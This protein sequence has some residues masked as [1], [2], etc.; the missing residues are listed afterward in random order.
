MSYFLKFLSNL[1]DPNLIKD[2]TQT[3]QVLTSEELTN[4]TD[5]HPRAMTLYTYLYEKE[6]GHD[7]LKL[8]QLKKY[9][10]SN[11]HGLFFRK[12]A[13]FKVNTTFEKFKTLV[14]ILTDCNKL[15]V[16]DS[17]FPHY[18]RE[19]IVKNLQSIITH[20]ITKNNSDETSKV[21]LET[22]ISFYKLDRSETFTNLIQIC[23]LKNF[24]ITK[25]FLTQFMGIKLDSI[26]IVDLILNYAMNPDFPLEQ[27]PDLTKAIIE[28]SASISAEEWRMILKH[29]DKIQTFNLANK[30]FYHFFLQECSINVFDLTASS[31]NLLI[32]ESLTSWDIF[33]YLP[34]KL[35]PIQAF[36]YSVYI[37]KNNPSL[38]RKSI[39]TI[40]K[41]YLEIAHKENKNLTLEEL[42]PQFPMLWWGCNKNAK[43]YTSA[44]FWS[45]LELIPE[46]IPYL[47]EGKAPIIAQNLF[48]EKG[49]IFNKLVTQLLNDGASKGEISWAYLAY[50]VLVNKLLKNRDDFQSVY[51][52]LEIKGISSNTY[53]AFISFFN[54]SFLPEISLQRS[55]LFGGINK[56]T[57]F[58]LLTQD[59]DYSFLNDCFEMMKRL[60]SLKLDFTPPQGTA[61]W[62]EYHDYLLEE[63]QKIKVKGIKLQQDHLINALHNKEFIG[64]KVHV[65]LFS[66]DFVW[67]G[68]SLGICVGTA[69]YDRKV[70][71]KGS[72]IVFLLDG[73]KVKYVIEFTHDRI[74]QAKGNS[75]SDMNPMQ[76]TLLKAFMKEHWWN[77]PRRTFRNEHDPYY[78]G[79]GDFGEELDP[80][81]YEEDF[82]EDE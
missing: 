27:K 22:L 2:I 80:A 11:F 17:F 6:P 66:E 12:A 77:N 21:F 69:G 54:N 56:E 33:S 14:T 19:L 55:D 18:P 60:S 50:L 32:A 4:R 43:T 25:K 73:K 67:A 39:I 7:E 24:I 8:V 51:A 57:K 64:M 26:K 40:L 16:I 48:G 70:A 20:V 79:E 65:P 38:S 10:N 78:E 58:L 29:R 5:L 59:I 53:A 3:N 76:Q 44:K 45:K 82:N 49:A 75:N 68:A 15:S 42:I 72:S 46:V 74:I 31:G 61:S 81:D 34:P 23:E 35:N 28:K 47:V 13:Q 1:S 62:K 63:N 52:S 37:K 36:T 41:E 71:S 9:L 30:D